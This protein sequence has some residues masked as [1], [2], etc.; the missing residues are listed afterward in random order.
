MFDALLIGLFAYICGSIPF[1]WLIGKWIGGIDI[2]TVGSGNVGATNIGRTMGARWGICVLVLDA[3]KGLLP[4][5]LLPPLFTDADAP[6]FVHLKVIAAV[7]AILGHMCPVW[8]GFKGGKGVAT[9]LGVV[10]VLSPYA[11]LGALVAFGIVFAWKRIVSIASIFAV[12]AFGITHFCVIGKEAFSSV[13]WS[14]SLFAIAAPLLIIWRH[15]SNIVRLIRGEEKAFVSGKI[16]PKMEAE[17]EQET[18]TESE[19]DQR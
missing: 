17:I 11:S 19:A 3:L 4:V 10:L 14:L 16:D 7:A 1:A 9:A 2:R 8:L 15:R 13:Y 5:L 12:L 6:D 18:E